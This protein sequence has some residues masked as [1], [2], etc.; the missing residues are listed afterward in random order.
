MERV[1]ACPACGS[2]FCALVRERDGVERCLHTG[3]DLAPQPAKPLR[4][5]GARLRARRAKGAA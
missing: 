1:T 5:E 3:R 2:R 4:P